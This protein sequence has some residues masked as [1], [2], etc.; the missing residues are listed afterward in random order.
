IEIPRV[1][2]RNLED[3]LDLVRWERRTARIE[4]AE[5]EAVFEQRRVEVPQAWSQLATD[6]VASRYFAGRQGSRERES[7]VR[8]L[9][10]RVVDTIAGW[11]RDARLLATRKDV[12]AFR[13]ELAHVLV[14]QKAAFN[15]PVWFNVGVER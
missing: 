10:S 5:G 11:V 4:D 1:F 15:S 13:D 3:P 2:T 6:L 12:A 8:H 9:V 7:S 14:H